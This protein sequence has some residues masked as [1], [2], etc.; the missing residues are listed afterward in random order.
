MSKFT[1]LNLDEI[2]T[3]CFIIDEEALE[4]NLKVLDSVQNR[5]GC[6]ILLALKGF[7]MYSTFPLVKKYLTGA[8][9]GSLHEARLGFEELGKEVHTY[10]PAFKETEIK[11]VIRYSDHIIFNSLNQWNK[12]KP[13]IEEAKKTGKRIEVGLRINP[14]YSEAFSEHYNPCRPKSRFGVLAQELFGQ[15]LEGITGLHFHALC[16]KYSDSLEKVLNAVDKKFESYIKQMKWMN[17]GGGHWITK[18]DYNIDHLCKLINDFK[19]HYPNIEQVYLEPG[20]AIALDAGILV[21]SVLDI[22]QNQGNVAILDFSPEAHLNDLIV[23]PYE[24]EIIGAGKPGENPYEYQLGA[25]SC[26]TGDVLGDYSFP[27]PLKVGDKL[28]LANMA[29]YTMS[30]TSTFCGV[31]LPDIA[32]CDKNGKIKIVRTFRYKDYKS[33]L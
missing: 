9:A 19:K 23:S 18:K 1:N 25:P 7:A 24:Q 21:T 15:N 31:K 16:E 14:E 2:E 26:A 28:I 30:K 11:E 5:A 17:F 32:I 3:P 12:F 4:E 27:E 22:K 20:E 13:A 29:I 33:R 8:C 10:A 6:N